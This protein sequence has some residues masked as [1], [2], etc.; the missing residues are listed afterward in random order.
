MVIQPFP[1]LASNSFGSSTSNVLEAPEAQLLII[2][3]AQFIYISRFPNKL[4]QV[5]ASIA[6][7]DGVS[8]GMVKLY[9]SVSGHPP[10]MDLITR[11]DVPLSRLRD[12]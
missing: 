1:I 10:M 11:K 8:L 4:N 12:T 9:V 6:L 5:Q 2:T 3:G 7:P